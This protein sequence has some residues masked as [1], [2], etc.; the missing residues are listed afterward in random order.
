MIVYLNGT[1]ISHHQ[2]NVPIF[3]RGF[4][5]GDGVFT[6]LKVFNG[7]PQFFEQ[8]VLR[9][10][11]DCQSLNILCPIISEQ[12]IYDL[13]AHNQ[14][15]HGT[16][17][18][19]IILTGAER[20]I[21]SNSK[22]SCDLI[23]MMMEPYEGS[24]REPLNLVSYPKPI[25]KPTS[26]IKSLAYL[27]SM[28]VK[29]FALSNGCNDAIIYSPNGY[30]LETAFCNIFWFLDDVFYTPSKDLGVL[31]GIALSVVKE[32]VT[33]FGIPTCEVEEKQIP[34][35]SKMFICNCL[36]GVQ[37][38]AKVDNQKLDYDRTLERILNEKFNVFCQS[39][40]SLDLNKKIT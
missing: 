2:A 32:I 7:R 14:A 31:P 10:K 40:L 30:V 15:F 22:R 11:D 17:R 24:N 6:T 26:K 37:S 12:T 1:F 16:W 19:K 29:E 5:F 4:L 23:L 18:L 36:K 39:N 33:A 34:D 9:L 35:N 20:D 21:S 38:V 13:I 3:N 8:H 28:L 25:A 27:D